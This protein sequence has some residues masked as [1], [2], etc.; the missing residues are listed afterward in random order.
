MGPVNRDKVEDTIRAGGLSSGKRDEFAK[1]MEIW[2]KDGQRRGN[3][4]KSSPAPPQNFLGWGV[5]VVLSLVV[6]VASRFLG[7]ASE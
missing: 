2:F 1:L 4:C 6:G 5:L 7:C 3:F